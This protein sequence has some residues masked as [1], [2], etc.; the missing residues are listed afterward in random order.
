LG[1]G[2][3]PPALA[4]CSTQAVILWSE[5]HLSDCGLLIFGLFGFLTF[6]LIAGTFDAS[7]KQSCHVHV[8]FGTLAF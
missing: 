1:G 3:H 4:H 7:K 6:L 2:A 5:G 8:G